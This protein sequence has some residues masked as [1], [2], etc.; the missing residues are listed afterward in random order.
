M[1][2]ST[3]KEA[4]SEGWGKWRKEGNCMQPDTKG[5]HKI[6][7]M[8]QSA[9]RGAPHLCIGNELTLWK[10]LRC[11]QTSSSCLLKKEKNRQQIRIE[12]LQKPLWTLRKLENKT[13]LFYADEYYQTVGGNK[14]DSGCVRRITKYILT[15]EK[16]RYRKYTENNM[17][18]NIR[19]VICEVFWSASNQKILCRVFKQTWR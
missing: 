9:K 11:L 4:Q 17:P 8:I 12:T 16:G 3:K 18:V 5:W 14:Q 1:E 6:L 15:R 13:L 10:K 2:N 7:C 19:S